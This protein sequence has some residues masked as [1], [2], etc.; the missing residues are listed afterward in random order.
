M[1]KNR[2]IP[3]NIILMLCILVF[4]SLYARHQSQADFDAK[5]VSFQNMTTA[6]EQVTENYLEGEQR[7]CDVWAHY[8][9]SHDMT[10][11]EAVRFIRASHVSV[12]AAAHV[13]YTDDGSMEGLSTRPRTGSDDDF[14]VSYQNL[15]LFPDLAQIG[16]V[17]ESVHIT[18]AY[19]SPVSG[20]QSIGFYNKLALV[21]PDT[22]LPREGIV[23]RVVPISELRSKWVFPQ[24]EYQN[25]EF[26]MIDAAGE[27]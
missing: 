21:D 8:I 14:G 20:I 12:H 19:T 22:G 6:M 2:L 18:R 3:V 5:V 23:V 13:L 25:A 7:I 15:D 26:S 24:E 10:L 9:S 4:V 17:G 1:K 27:R 16:A 11:E